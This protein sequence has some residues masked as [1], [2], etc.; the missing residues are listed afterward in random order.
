MCHTGDQSRL[1]TVDFFVPPSALFL[2]SQTVRSLIFLTCTILTCF[3]TLSEMPVN[4]REN[5]GLENSHLQPVVLFFSLSSSLH[6]HPCPPPSLLPL[7]PFCQS[8]TA[9]RLKP[10]PFRR[11]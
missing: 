11:S 4:P 9:S 5:H 8:L 2:R 7:P 3:L 6:S 10:R 1:V